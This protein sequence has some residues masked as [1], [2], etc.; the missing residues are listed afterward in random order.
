MAATRDCV[1]RVRH[2]FY[3]PAD[4]VTG[5]DKVHR[6]DIVSLQDVQEKDIEAPYILDP[7]EMLEPERGDAPGD[8]IFDAMGKGSAECTFDPEL[9]EEISE[10]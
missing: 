6:G 4:K 8:A 9:I 2:L 7:E 3:F 10:E 5:L 1:N